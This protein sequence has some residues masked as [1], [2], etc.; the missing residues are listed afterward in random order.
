MDKT[1]ID[2]KCQG[3]LIR[4]APSDGPGEPLVLFSNVGNKKAREGL[5]LRLS[6]DDG[7]TWTRSKVLHPGPS[8]YSCLATLPNGKV[9]CLFEGGSGHPY[10][11]IV[12]ESFELSW[13]MEKKDG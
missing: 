8:A 11:T 6:A 2:P 9:A 1:L 13:L 12:Y 4:Y 7:E 5:T 10:E 3:S